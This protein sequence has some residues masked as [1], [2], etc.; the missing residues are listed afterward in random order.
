MGTATQITTSIDW[1][2]S[3]KGNLWAV[4]DAK[5]V[6]VFRRPDRRFGVCVANQHGPVFSQKTF[7]HEAAAVR[8]AEE[9][10]KSR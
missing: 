10:V 2:R 3:K 5:T 1:Q 7:R 9:R 8:H 6:T 4:V